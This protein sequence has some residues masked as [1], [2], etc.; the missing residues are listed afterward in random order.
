MK[1]V[2][3]HYKQGHITIVFG[4]YGNEQT[5]KS[6]EQRWRALVKSSVDINGLLDALTTTSQEEFLNN[7]HMSALIA[8]VSQALLPKGIKVVQTK[9]GADLSIAISASEAANGYTVVLSHDTDVLILLLARLGADVLLVQP[10]SGKP[11]KVIRIQQLKRSLG[12]RLC[13][14]LLS[15]HAMT[16][17]DTTSASCCKGNKRPFLLAK[18]SE[19]FSLCLETLNDKQCSKAKICENGENLMLTIYNVEHFRIFMSHTIYSY[20]TNVCLTKAV[21]HNQSKF[22]PSHTW[23]CQHAFIP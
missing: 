2:N 20:Q 13:S 3:T 17:C 15:M 10:Q 23:L 16:G 22:P 6:L 5:T 1:Y 21:F 14:I 8:A 11:D 9:G 7:A 18:C 4:G 19:S 12:P